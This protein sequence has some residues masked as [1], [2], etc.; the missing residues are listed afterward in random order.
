MS[1]PQPTTQPTQFTHPTPPHPNNQVEYIQSIKAVSSE[2]G[3]QAE[4]AFY[5]R[6]PEEAERILLQASPP[7]VYRAIKLNLRM[8]KWQR[9]LDLALKYKVHV[10]TVLAYRQRYLEEFGK[11]ESLSKFQQQGEASGGKADWEAV[12]AA[13]AQELSDEKRRGGGGGG[14]K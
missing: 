3:R 1:N 8:Y 11:T 5:R 10:P 13:E 7:L 14:R 6:Q 9:A 4:L 12:L 2:E